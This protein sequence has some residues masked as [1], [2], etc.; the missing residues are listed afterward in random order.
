[1]VLGVGRGLVAAL[2][3]PTDTVLTHQ[4]F[5]PFL[6]DGKPPCT[7]LTHHPRAAISPFEFGVNGLDQR[8]QLGIGQPVAIRC[9]ATLPRPIPTDADLK[10]PAKR[11]Q[12]ELMTV[13]I[14]PGVF[15]SA[16][17]AKYA[18]AFFKIRGVNAAQDA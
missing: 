5:H 3:A 18:V 7:Q 2:V 1:V 15:H 4:P 11:I 10:D 17:F 14:N 12:G 13:R 9:A 16:S 6:A 8:K